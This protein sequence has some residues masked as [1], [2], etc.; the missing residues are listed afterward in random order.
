MKTTEWLA[1]L[2]GA[3]L[4]VTG[5]TDLGRGVFDST[6]ALIVAIGAPR[7]RTLGIELPSSLPDSPEHAL[8]RQLGAQHGVEAHSKYNALLR[9]LVSFERALDGRMRRERAREQDS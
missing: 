5:L 2:P 8:Y 7:L 3:E 1:D 6:E 9:R 4:V